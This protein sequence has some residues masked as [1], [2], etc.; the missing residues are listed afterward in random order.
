MK[1]RS[2]GDA[3]TRSR[4][5]LTDFG[6][7]QIRVLRIAGGVPSHPDCSRTDRPERRQA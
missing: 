6:V 4:L 5:W 3:S 7:A 2:Q 1:A